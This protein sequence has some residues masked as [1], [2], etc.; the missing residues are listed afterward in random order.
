MAT[1]TILHQYEEWLAARRERGEITQDT[2]ATYLR[3]ASRVFEVL[4]RHLP[5]S[6]IEAYMEAEGYQGTYTHVVN[7]LRVMARERG[8]IAF[9][10]PDDAQPRLP[11]V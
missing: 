2:Y 6:V 3:E 9:R 5:A 4:L 10:T 1:T 7:A 8:H 11:G